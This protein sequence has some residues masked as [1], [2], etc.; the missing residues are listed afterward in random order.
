MQHQHGTTKRQKKLIAAVPHVLTDV[1]V[2]SALEEWIVYSHEDIPE[3]WYLE[4]QATDKTNYY[5]VD[6]YW[7]NVLQLRNSSGQ[8]KFMKL[9]K[10]I[11]CLLTIS[12]ANADVERS[13]SHNKNV[14]ISERSSLSPEVFSKS[15]FVNEQL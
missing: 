12:H 2:D 10:F 3:N 14:L 5:R 4:E 8:P 9:Q 15:G 7:K 13:L 1:E 11:P 6:Q